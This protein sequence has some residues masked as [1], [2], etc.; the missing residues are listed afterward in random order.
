[1]PGAP[2]KPGGARL[3]GIAPPIQELAFADII[4]GRNVLVFAPTAG[5]K[6]EAAMLPLLNR[7]Q[8]HE[9]SGVKI[10][11]LAPLRAL[12]NNLELR[13]IE[14]QLCDA[15]YFTVFK[16][17][18]DVDRSKRLAAARQSPDS[19]D[20]LL[21]TPESLD[22]IL[23]S[24]FVKASEFFAPLEAVVID[25][26][27][28]FAGSERGGQLVSALHRLEQVLNRDLQRVCLSATIGNPKEVIEWTTFP[29]RRERVVIRPPAS[30][31]ERVIELNYYDKNDPHMR[32]K[33]LTSTVV[34]A[35]LGKKISLNR[36]ARQQNPD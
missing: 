31:P 23:C 28:Y 17:H 14:T 7:L 6:T 34:Q 11:Y 26:T 2:T 18:G 15:V 3:E 5:G 8:G 4:A 12:L 27:H 25:E 30:T 13:F 19:P 1:M 10:L 33:A 35:S 22:V 32:L 16:W 24:P 29:S 9:Q 36:V 21:S 20:V